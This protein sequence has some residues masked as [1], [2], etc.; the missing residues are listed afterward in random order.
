MKRSRKPKRPNWSLGI[1]LCFA[2][3]SL[4]AATDTSQEALERAGDLVRQHRLSEAEAQAKLALSDSATSPL[5]YALLGGI[6]LEQKDLAESITF[7]E[8]AVD[9]DPRLVGARLNLAEAY[10]LRGNSG[11]ALENY[12]TVAKL[13]PE[14]LPAI[15]QAAAIAEQRG[16]LER[17][18][19]WWIRAKK[20]QPDD[21]DILFG[22]GRACL[23]M[24]LLDDAEPALARAVKL[25]PGQVSYQYVLASARVGKKQFE[26]AE[27]L[28]REL[29]AKKPNDA[30]LHYALGSVYYLESKLE[31]AEQQFRASVRIEPKQLASWYYLGLVTR[32]RGNTEEAMRIF[33]ELLKK[34]PD[35][36]ASYE[37]LGM[38][39]MRTEQYPEAER[40]LEKAVALNPKSVKSNYQLGLLLGRMGKKEESAKQLEIARSLQKEDEAQA[41]L[42]LRLLDPEQ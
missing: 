42:Q 10:W 26:S 2:V 16:E 3:V 13:K 41:R 33:R 22:F 36:A 27:R 18:L 38:L 39:L 21:P 32:D 6:K 28:L 35:H 24:D 1:G 4:R 9:L 12:E 30:Q 31:E 23:K 37:A 11:R 17:S 19:S 34:H 25:R 15:R 5:A 14:F 7:L 20:L 29:V 40:D 8:K